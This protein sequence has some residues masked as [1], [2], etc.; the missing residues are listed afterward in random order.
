MAN[1]EHYAELC[2]G[3]TAAVAHS[4]QLS[5]DEW[6]ELIEHLPSCA[7]CQALI[8]DF[9]EVSFNL[10]QRSNAVGTSANTSLRL[11]LHPGKKSPQRITV[12]PSN[13]CT[14]PQLGGR[15]RN[16]S[17]MIWVGLAVAASMAVCFAAGLRVAGY[18]DRPGVPTQAGDMHPSATPDPAAVLVEENT[19]LAARL[20]AAEQRATDALIESRSTESKLNS[21]VAEL[22]GA[23]AELTR[24]E[25]DAASQSAQLQ[26]DLGNL[27]SENEAN[28]NSVVR[29]EA[30]VADRRVELK[31]IS[32]Q[33][34]DEKRKN[35]SLT[36]AQDFLENPDS[37]VLPIYDHD[38]NGQVLSGRLLYTPGR[39]LVF[40][41]YNLPSGVTKG[42]EIA[43]CVWGEKP[44]THEPIRNLGV[45][46]ADSNKAGRWKLEFH[47]PNVLAKIDSVFVTAERSSTVVEPHGKKMFQASL[48]LK[49]GR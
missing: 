26:T 14:E 8:G 13:A 49:A 20:S 40:Y 37:R 44:A 1:H 42:A 48:D 45:L 2:A 38:E 33:L 30:E 28:H 24:R 22:E 34:E 7:E 39:E 16:A 5:E 43:L 23:N 4:G 31:R 25:S 18:R 32:T 19:R 21:R 11:R 27:R 36:E 6:R 46:R 41:A 29:A 12:V 9:A 47:D 17:R 15:R 10:T 3:A 35:A